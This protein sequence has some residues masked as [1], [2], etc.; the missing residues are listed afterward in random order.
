MKFESIKEGGTYFSTQ[1]RK[2]GN[3]T[4]STLSVVRMQVRSV[5]A[6]KRSVRASWNSNPERTF[7]E[8]DFNKWR[9][10]EPVLVGTMTKRLATRAELAAMNA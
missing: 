3:T 10:A 6:E 5:D 9:L 4:L 1:R 2:M 7:F 8:R